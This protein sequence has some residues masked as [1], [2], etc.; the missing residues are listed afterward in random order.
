MLY[1][2]DKE[3]YAVVEFPMCLQFTFGHPN[4]EVLPGHPLFKNGLNYYTVHRI[5]NSSKL[6]ALEKCN[7]VH[8]RHN[9]K[10]FLKDMHHYIFTFQDSTL[11]CLVQEGASWKSIVTV[12]DEEEA[13]IQAFKSKIPT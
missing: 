8:P 2:T 1:Y 10:Q 9:S 6:A 7:A 5:E 3:K 11:E 4:D 13:A 12:Y